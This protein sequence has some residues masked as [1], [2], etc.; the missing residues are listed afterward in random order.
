[1]KGGYRLLILISGFDI[2]VSFILRSWLVFVY[3]T[4]TELCIAYPH[5]LER[6]DGLLKCLKVFILEKDDFMINHPTDFIFRVHTHGRK[7]ETDF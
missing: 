2:V 6:M 1:M 5:A 4:S 7:W 3:I